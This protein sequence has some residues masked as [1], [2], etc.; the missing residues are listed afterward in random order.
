MKQG[1]NFLDIGC[2]FGQEL[3]KLSSDGAPSSNLYGIGLERSFV[4]FGF[5]LFRDR[6]RLESTFLTGDIFVEEPDDFAFIAGKI[7]II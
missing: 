6:D 3:R 2:C 1:D 5:E 4:D 7:D